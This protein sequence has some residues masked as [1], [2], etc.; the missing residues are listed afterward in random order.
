[1]INI[2]LVVFTL[3]LLGGLSFVIPIKN[4]ADRSSVTLAL[5]LASKLSKRIDVTRVA[6]VSRCS[7]STSEDDG[8][9]SFP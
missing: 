5:I 8:T 9:I 4:V 1:M 3:I 6:R 7:A 2:G